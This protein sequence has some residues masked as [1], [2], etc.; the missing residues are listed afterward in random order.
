[1]NEIQTVTEIKIPKIKLET[2]NPHFKLNV[3]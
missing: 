3:V 1:M 2:H